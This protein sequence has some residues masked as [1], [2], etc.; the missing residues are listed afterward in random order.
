MSGKI[1]VNRMLHNAFFVVGMIAAIIIL[2]LTVLAP[3][4]CKF[5]PVTNSLSDRFMAPEWFARGLEGHILGTDNLG[6]DIFSRLLYGAGNTF[7]VAFG[8]AAISIALG[9]VLGILA[10][11]F[12]G[13]VDAV[14]MRAVDVFQSVPAVVLGIVVLSLFGSGLGKFMLVLG[15]CQ[16]VKVCKV[17]RNN[18]RVQKG[19][20]YANASKV[21]GAGKA[22]IM[23]TQ[24]F[25]NVTTG[26]IIQ[27]S[28]QIGV[29][30][31]LQAVFAYIGLGVLPP[32]PSWGHMI[33]AGRE[34]LTVYPWM[35]LV[36]GVALMVTAIAFNFLG[37]GLRDVLD[38]KRVR[39]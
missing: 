9:T 11:Y 3:V 35:A 19:M 18:V 15:I 28:Q 2:V 33:S 1:I 32:A 14:I 17:T 26:I 24:I 31:L 36:P 25:P 39:V 22:H 38:P 16:W 27:G 12:G 37:D 13:W 20:D 6:R 30:I 21:L 23:F 10:G 29:L 5:D 4:L 7:I 8:A 34:Y